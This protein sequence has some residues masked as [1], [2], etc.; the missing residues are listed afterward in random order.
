MRRLEDDTSYFSARVAR[1]THHHLAS[2]SFLQP[3]ASSLVDS[4]ASE[5]AV[6]STAATDDVVGALHQRSR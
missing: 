1:S 6:F 4:S 5:W 2:L 3:H